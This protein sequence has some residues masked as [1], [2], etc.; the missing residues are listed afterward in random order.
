MLGAHMSVAGGLY[1]AFERAQTVG[2]ET[3]QIFTKSERQWNAKPISEEDLEL[4]IKAKAANSVTPILT[5]DSYLI[6]LASPD[7]DLWEKSLAA[8]EHEIERNE[9][10]AI[11]YLVTHVGAHMGSGEEAGCDKVAVAINRIQSNWDNLKT[12]ILFE[13]T[14]GQGTAIGYKF[15]HWGR[16]F[17]QLEH[18]EWVGVCF[19]TCHVFAGGYD[20]TTSEAYHE[21]M[22]LFDS[23]IGTPK[24]KAF[25][26][27]DSKKGLFSRVDRHEAIGQGALGLEPFRFIMNDPRYK[28]V[29]KIIETPKSPDMHEDIENLATL[30]S[31]I[32][33]AE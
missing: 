14:A 1:K 25:H 19:D 7:S 2:C 30:R 29:P 17:E 13:T 20:M 15:E 22:R 32:G 33:N 26:L 5:H 16:I 27:N 18:P 24:I 6:N 4:W 3:M 12:M 8:F 10:L 9:M 28:A 11:P 23:Y 31:L 21:T